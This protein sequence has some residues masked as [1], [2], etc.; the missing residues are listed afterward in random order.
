MEHK[1]KKTALYLVAFMFFFQQSIEV[2]LIVESSMNGL[3]VR[4]RYEEKMR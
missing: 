3:V 1:I 2:F 4:S